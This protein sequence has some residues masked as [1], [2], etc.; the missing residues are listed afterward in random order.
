MPFLGAGGELLGVHLDRAVA[1]HADD[2]LVRAADL[3]PH[4]GGQAEAHRAQATGVD[5]APRAGEVEVLRRPHLVL[6]DVGGDDRVA[7]GRLVEGLDHVLRLDLG[8][9][10]VLVAERVALLPDPNARPP[11][12]QPRRLC[13]QRAVLGGQPG[14]MLRASPTIG[15]CA[16]TFLEISAGSMSMWMNLARGANSESLPVTRSSKRAPMATIRSAS[17]MA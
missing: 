4:G 13:G 12:L 10:G 16:G 8:V 6:A 3:G 9:G 1:R 7:A 2:R 17:S 11:L 5:P 15:M 14:T